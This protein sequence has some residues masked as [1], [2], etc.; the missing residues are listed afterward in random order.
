M[1]R[2]RHSAG[3]ELPR[4]ASAKLP[5]RK[6]REDRTARWAIARRYTTGERSMKSIQALREQRAAKAREL[7][8]LVNKADWNAE[9][10]QPIY[11]AGMAE[12]DDLD[13]QIK[14]IS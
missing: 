5:E 9:R 6:P 3:S 10:D 7:H 12:L 14:R 8:D 1:M 2:S 13:G 4:C 11:D